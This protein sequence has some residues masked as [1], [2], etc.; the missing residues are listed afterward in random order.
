MKRIGT[1]NKLTL[2][3]K[4]NEDVNLCK[5]EIDFDTYHIFGLYHE[6]LDYLN[7]QVEFVLRKD[8]YKGEEIEI[9][10]NFVDRRVIT[11]IEK[12]EDIKLIPKRSARGFC[13]F[14]SS[15]MKFGDTDMNC[16]A[17]MVDYVLGSSKRT[18]WVDITCL[19][20]FSKVFYVKAFIN[21]LDT[22]VNPEEVL[23][24]CKGNFIKLSI[25]STQYGLQCDGIEL[26]ETNE[27]LAPE[28]IIARQRIDELVK[29]D[30][31]LS[32]YADRYN[33]LEA[34]SGIIEFDIGYHLINIAAELAVINT[35]DNITNAY[36]IRLLYRAAVTSRGCLLPSK[37]RFSNSMLNVNRV[38][39]SE[40]KGDVEL[41]KIL[42]I[43][44]TEPCEE[45]D[46]Y[47]K[48]RG[49][50]DTINRQKRGLITNEERPYISSGSSLYGMY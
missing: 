33:L 21:K 1:V 42:D 28:V 11:T 29:K 13:T 44:C 32:A 4:I 25:S 48:V 20:K 31:E 2:V 37:T 3:E 38:L 17:L 19:D 12:Q 9:V 30:S 27:T 14:D 23:D 50:V 46:I 47:L 45:K 24:G 16:I 7:C 40:L 49:F 35:V 34:L 22:P 43:G 39:N 26:Y 5:I 15:T 10:A 41:L 36:D 8:V 6:L 18:K